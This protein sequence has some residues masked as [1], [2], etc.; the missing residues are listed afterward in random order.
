MHDE[1]LNVLLLKI[2]QKCLVHQV[3]SSPSFTAALAS[4]FFTRVTKALHTEPT[5]AEFL[6]REG[7]YGG[8][9]KGGS[10]V[11]G[12]CFSGSNIS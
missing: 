9:G 4:V 1:V 3:G 12:G 6:T 8:W 2:S 7:S 11:E 5:G 10:A